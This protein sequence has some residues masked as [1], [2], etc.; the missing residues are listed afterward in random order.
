MSYFGKNQ[1]KDAVRFLLE[2]GISNDIPVA[3]ALCIHDCG[4]VI[5]I[6]KDIGHGMGCNKTTTLGTFKNR[7]KMTQ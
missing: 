2:V 6:T 4:K 5:D 1:F 3:P 7:P